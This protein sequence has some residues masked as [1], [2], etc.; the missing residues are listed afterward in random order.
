MDAA[1]V[2]AME[3]QPWIGKAVAILVAC[4]N[5]PLTKQDHGTT[6]VLVEFKAGQ[7]TLVREVRE[8]TLRL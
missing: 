2:Q 4:L 7:F 1:T 8:K 5:E 6:G 3:S